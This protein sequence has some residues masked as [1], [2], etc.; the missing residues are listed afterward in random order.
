VRPVPAKNA[1]PVKRHRRR[2]SIPKPVQAEQRRERLIER[3][4]TATDAAL[5]ALLAPAGYGKTTLLAQAARESSSRVAWLTLTEDEASAMRLAH[6]VANA[7]TQA[8]PEVE[9]QQYQTALS[10]D[11]VAEGL[12]RALAADLNECDHNLDLVLDKAEHL[13]EDATKWL[14][15]YLN[16]LDEGHRVLMAGYD[17]TLPMAQLV[18]S[19]RAM[20][21]E[22]SELAF[23]PEETAAYLLARGS[24]ANATEAHQVLD[25]WCA[26]LALVAAGAAP[27]LEPRDLVMEVLE[28]L[29][30]DLCEVI[31][32]AAVLEVWSE[33]EAKKIGCNLPRGWLKTAQ[34]VGLPM[35]PLTSDSYRPHTILLETLDNKLRENQN[36]YKKLYKVSGDLNY[37]QGNI[38]KS[39]EYLRKAESINEALQIFE[40]FA[41][42]AIDS[43]SGYE[44]VCTIAEKFDYSQLTN[45]I[46]IRYAKSLMLT[47]SIVKS[48]E[49]LDELYKSKI[50]QDDPM[51]LL[52]YG[53][54][55]FQLGKINE[56][57]GVIEFAL[58]QKLTPKEMVHFLVAKANGL[59][60]MNNYDDALK[61]IEKSTKISTEVNDLFL[62][63]LTSRESMNIYAST[64][65][66]IAAE[67]FF[68]KSV[69]IADRRKSISEKMDIYNEFARLLSNWGRKKE[70]LGLLNQ[71]VEETKDS[72]TGSEMLSH[73][74]RGV[75][76]FRERNLEKAK[77]DIKWCIE[78]LPP[79]ISSGSLN[80]MYIYLIQIYLYEGKTEKAGLFLDLARKVDY[81]KDVPFYKSFMNLTEAYYA[82]HTKD[83]NLSQ[84]FFIDSPDET[85]SLW[86]TTRKY[87]YL[88]DISRRNGDLSRTLINRMIQVMDSMQHDYALQTDLSLLYDLYTNCIDRGW[89]AD[90]FLKVIEYKSEIGN[91]A[92]VS[93]EAHDNLAIWIESESTRIPLKKSAELLIWLAIHGPATRDEIITAL[94]GKNFTSKDVEY[95][96]VAARRLRTA[97]S[98]HPSVTFNPLPFEHGVYR[99]SEQFDINLDIAPLISDSPDSSADIL[100][101]LESYRGEFLPGFQGEWIENIRT[102]ALD[103]LLERGLELGRQLEQLDPKDAIRVYDRIRALDSLCEPAYQ[104]LERV[105]RTLGQEANA[106]DTAKAWQKALRS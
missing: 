67:S 80:S 53:Q 19:G 6:S 14:E 68:K 77:I 90:R 59:W 24:D 91:L 27:Q 54:K 32:E 39:I 16:E 98:E 78:R 94:W 20:R 69:E 71:V 105:Y 93:I 72:E 31:P 82:F 25:G 51:L 22:T 62:I 49:M 89:Y 1:Q 61:E 50:W 38:I 46:K 26:G 17:T 41:V 29:P 79:E 106:V 81:P 83:Y 100:E 103:T 85:I 84:R 65:N 10:N 75:L 97:L 40:A 28:R 5:V 3:I 96:K 15:R 73:Y 57:L 42:N 23:T 66:K 13:G 35:T 101:L 48:S 76:Y 95:F 11:A 58:Q 74:L 104:G 102:R 86:E 47:D 55:L 43:Y 44:I 60:F 37:T 92:K 2:S 56:Y 33:D 99:I 7:V 34:R 45:K 4:S 88:A 9:F 70:S 36:T 63:G 30:K 87:A 21:L 18:A 12:A 8:L 64:G 52:F